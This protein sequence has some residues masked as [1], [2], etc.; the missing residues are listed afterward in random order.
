MPPD[1]YIG[2]I[3][4]VPQKSEYISSSRILLKSLKMVKDSTPTPA[5]SM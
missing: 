2:T 4:P 3:N 5:L 1:L